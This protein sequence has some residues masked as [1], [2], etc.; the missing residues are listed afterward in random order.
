M[1]QRA[2]QQAGASPNKVT[3]SKAFGG[4]DAAAMGRQEAEVA[5]DE[6]RQAVPLPVAQLAERRALEQLVLVP[7]KAPLVRQSVPTH[8]RLKSRAAVRGG[9]A[10]RRRRDR[11]GRFY[12]GKIVTGLIYLLTLG[13]FGLG[14]LYD[15]LTLNSQIS[16]KNLQS[17]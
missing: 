15:F 8:A 5:S 13:L 3:V 12:M 9:V 4:A 17:Q 16:E 14:V 10:T 11:H 7:S 6:V 1:S 2:G